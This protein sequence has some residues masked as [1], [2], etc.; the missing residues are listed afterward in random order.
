MSLQAWRERGGTVRIGKHRV[1]RVLEGHGPPALLVHGFP[2]AS[3]GWHRIWPRLTD[4]HSA[5]APDLLGF[6]FSDK[7]PGGPYGIDAQ[8][9]LLEAVLEGAGLGPPFVLASAY[10]VTLAQEMLARHAERGKPLVRAV[11]FLNGGL[12][13]EHNPILP[14]QKL[15][16]GPLGGLLFRVVPFGELLFR[17]NMRKVFGERNPPREDELR[18]YWRLLELN[19]GKGVVHELMRY[20]IER[21]ERRD[22]LVGALRSADVPLRLVLGTADP[23]SGR[24]AERWREV[25]PDSEPVLLDGSVGHYP[26]LEAPEAVLTAFEDLTRGASA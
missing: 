8:A 1:F 4:K 11:C 3:W 21:I 22:R 10:G 13:P 14:S 19:G 15:L 16:L 7:P 9:D 2:M 23:V 17:K 20:Q 6:G 18:D 12:F 24:Q 5:L 25:V 26:Q